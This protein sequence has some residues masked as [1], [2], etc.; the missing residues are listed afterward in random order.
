MEDYNGD[1]RYCGSDDNLYLINGYCPK[2]AEDHAG[3]I[4]AVAKRTYK[5]RSNVARPHQMAET[6]ELQRT[7]ARIMRANH[8]SAF[9]FITEYGLPRSPFYRWNS[10]SLVVR[11]QPI[12]N[13]KVRMALRDYKGEMK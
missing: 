2:C 11:Y 4:S 1:C 10:E 7:C 9:Q 5:K 8:M 3:E 13:R 12:F 6:V